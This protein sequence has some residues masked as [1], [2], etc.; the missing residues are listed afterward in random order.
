[1]PQTILVV[2]DQRS[3]VDLVSSVLEGVGYRVL[4]AYGGTQAL[5]VIGRESP[6]LVL[7]DI[8]MPDIDGY[9]V[10]RQ[11]RCGGYRGPFVFMSAGKNEDDVRKVGSAYLKKPFGVEDL[12]KTIANV[13]IGEAGVL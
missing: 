7:S 3:T 6:D 2:D 4:K 13:L 11:A 10:L 8:M 5:D 12:Q 1:M 9:E